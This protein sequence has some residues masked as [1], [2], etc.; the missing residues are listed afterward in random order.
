MNKYRK[1]KEAA[2]NRAIRYQISISGK[3]TSYYELLEAQAYFEKIGRRYGLLNEF[4]E[5]AIL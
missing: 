5:N 1:L 4:R 2:R 3:N